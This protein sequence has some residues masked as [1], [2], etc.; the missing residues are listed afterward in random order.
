MSARPCVTIV[1]ESELETGRG[2]LARL[3]GMLPQ[4]ARRFDI[5]VASLGDSDAETQALLDAH[6][7][8][9][10]ALDCR[11]EGWDLVDLDRQV[12]AIVGWSR[13]RGDA[14]LVMGWEL[15]GLMRGLAQACAS[16]GPAFATVVHAVPL[17]N[18]P[19]Q[20]SRRFV[21][22]ARRRA[23]DE[24]DPAIRRYLLRHAAEVPRM[25]PHMH[26]ISPNATVAWY[27]ARYFPH[28]T[29]AD[30]SPG[31]GI[32]L[33][34]AA[35]AAPSGPPVELAFMA[36]L[37]REKGIYDMVAIFAAL[38]RLRPE[39]RLRI[40]GSF[41]SS[42]EERAF[43]AECERTDVAD[44]IT[45]AG[46]LG[47]AAKLGALKSARVFVYPA[48][49]SDTFCIAMLEAIGCGLPVVAWDLPFVRQIYRDAPVTPVPMG[50]H[51]AFASAI[52]ATLDAGPGDA[53]KRAR[54]LARYDGWERA[55]EA[56]GDIWQAIIDRTA[57][58]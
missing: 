17:L 34:A 55:A 11:F 20:P 6:G 48:R 27:L 22:D 18:C 45:F 24:P 56:E 35:A 58:R 49:A 52:A 44:R 10:Y 1:I 9:T 38:L 13:A 4:L 26:L 46:W 37:V 8:A 21:L 43:H 14:L 23:A 16:G 30:A 42:A 47:G 5:A 51:A 19:P 29:V 25:L 40:I 53:A 12:A 54:F 3:R 57:V 36:K 41:E 31:Y 39:V 50:D 15:W 28:L 33:H 32:D 7:I 2:P